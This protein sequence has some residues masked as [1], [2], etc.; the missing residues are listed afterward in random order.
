MNATLCFCL[1]SL[2]P[3]EDV[4]CPSLNLIP[5]IHRHAAIDELFTVPK[6]NKTGWKF[7]MLNRS[8]V[9]VFPLSCSFSGVGN[10]PSKSKKVIYFYQ[11][12]SHAFI[13]HRQS[14]VHPSMS[15]EVSTISE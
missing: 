4:E 6:T 15:P 2:G 13:C 11:I 1:K 8:S 5:W 3:F 14:C 7:T 10:F 9:G 12:L